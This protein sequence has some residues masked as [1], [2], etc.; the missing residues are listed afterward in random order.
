M[1][2]PGERYTAT[3]VPTRTLLLRAFDIKAFQLSGTP[4]WIDIERYDIDARVETNGENPR[5]LSPAE[6]RPLLQDMLSSR[7]QLKFHREKK[8]MPVF[9]LVAARGGLGLHRNTGALGHEVDWGRDHINAHDVTIGEFARAL[10]TQLDRAVAD[11]TNLSGTFDFNLTWMPD[12]QRAE[13]LSGPSIFTAIREQ[14][15]L[16][17]KSR[18]GAVEIVVIDHLEKPSDN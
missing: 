8:V 7:F 18:K 12:A 1:T 13:D 17:L 2:P 14:Y 11:N 3:N 10:E 15:G 9:A 16:E 6:L 4:G 5:M